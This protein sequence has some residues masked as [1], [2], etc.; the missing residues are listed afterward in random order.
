MESFKQLIRSCTIKNVTI[1]AKNILAEYN[2][3]RPWSKIFLNITGRAPRAHVVNALIEKEEMAPVVAPTRGAPVGN[4]FHT[5]MTMRN[6]SITT[7]L[8]TIAH[9][10][11]IK[12]SKRTY[13]ALS[14]I[15]LR[16]LDSSLAL[17]GKRELTA[18]LK[19]FKFDT[20]ED[21]TV[22]DLYRTC[23]YSSKYFRKRSIDDV[24]GNNLTIHPQ[25]IKIYGDVLNLNIIRMDYGKI[26]YITN[27]I[28]ERATII[29]WEDSQ[30]IYSIKSRRS[31]LRGTELKTILKYDARIDTNTLDRG[32]DTVIKNL[33]RMKNINIRKQIHNRFVNK[34]R[35]ELVAEL[36]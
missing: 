17:L 9:T 29:L 7:P 6:R 15:L 23:N 26:D 36:T 16:T 14:I 33:C 18:Y 27:F 13:D 22:R 2:T 32:N 1:G 8:H 20:M 21:F 11:I 4:S 28:K 30:Y 3:P 10:F 35:A 25:M 12:E 24:F 5:L 31:F 34:T 19:T